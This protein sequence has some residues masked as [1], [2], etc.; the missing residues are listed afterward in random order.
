MRLYILRRVLAIVPVLFALGSLVF[1]MQHLLPGDPVQIMLG[2]HYD[3]PR[4]E[5]LRAALGLDLPLW[6]QFLSYWAGVLRGDLG[7]S[8]SMGIPVHEALLSTFPA[9]FRLAVTGITIAVVVGIGLGVLAAVRSG[10]WLD[11]VVMILALGGVSIPAFWFGLLLILLFAVTLGIAPVTGGGVLLPAIAVA[12]PAMGF[13]ARLVR[14]SMLDVLTADYL[15]TARARG[16]S[17]R[18]I[19]F[20]HALKNSFIPVLTVLGLLFGQLLGGTVVIESV[21]AR[22][23]LGRTLVL[24]IQSRDIPLVQGGVLL[25][26][27]T[28]VLINLIVDLCYTWLDPRV[29]LG[30][31][32]T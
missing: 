15:T 11:T 27:T 30:G 31:S 32:K 16:V 19:V 10:G 22:Q 4:A 1:F 5:S 24:A 28:Y 8:L 26:G 18:R 29:R 3:E 20:K 7:R 13:T 9:T 17:E 12:M 14:S 25:L 6:R 23:G 21:F 2:F